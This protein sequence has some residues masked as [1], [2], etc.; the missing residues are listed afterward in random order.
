MFQYVWATVYKT[1]YIM[2]QEDKHYYTVPCELIG[3][4]VKVAY[5]SKTVEVYYQMKHVA[6]HNRDTKKGARTMVSAHLPANIQFVN[7]LN[8]DKLISWATSIGKSTQ[9]MIT[10]IIDTRS[11]PDQARKSCM[12]ILQMSKKVGR[13]RLENACQRALYYASYGYRVIKSILE[14][15]L[16]MEPLQMDLDLEQYR[17]GNHENIRGS[18]YYK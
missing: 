6:S 2:L 11:H 17:I 18:S 10:H 9:Q 15:K 5:N 8:L 13:D 3:K 12:G 7:E 14:K 16:D 4:R 1:S